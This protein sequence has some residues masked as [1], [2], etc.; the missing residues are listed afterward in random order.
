M[1]APGVSSSVLLTEE[2]LRGRIAELGAEITS[3]YEGQPLTVLAILKGSVLFAAD[4][5][6]EIRLPL[7]LEFITARSYAGTRS[8][9]VVKW[10]D[11][12]STLANRHVL[13]V[14][15]IWDSGRTLEALTTHATEQSRALSIQSCVL[16]EK[17]VPHENSACPRFVGFRIPDVFVIGFGL[18]HDE[19]FR[20]LRH[21][22]A[23]E[24]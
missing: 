3:A 9:G 6:R 15:D 23:Y 19:E 7:Q 14:D 18:D 17:D 13:I 16:L 21:I 10:T 4:L 22:R 20:N 2:A 1:S 11:L 24:S 8:S 12:P 5:V